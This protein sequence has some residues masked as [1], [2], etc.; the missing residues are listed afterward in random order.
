MRN[1][2][3]TLVLLATAFM[4]VVRW[5][6]YAEGLSVTKVSSYKDETVADP[7]FDAINCRTSWKNFQPTNST[8]IDAQFFDDC[9]AEAALYD[10]VAILE[11]VF[12]PGD[13]GK[14]ETIVPA[15]ATTAGVRT[16]YDFNKT[17][18]FPVWWNPTFKTYAKNAIQKL[19]E[20]YDP[21]PRVAGYMASGFAG[22]LPTSLAGEQS[23]PL[24]DNFKAE[25]LFG[26]CDEG[27][28][29]QTIASG[30]PYGIAVREMLGFWASTTTKPVVYVARPLDPGTLAVELEANPVAL[31]PNIAIV[32]NGFR[33]C[34]GIRGEIIDRFQALQSQGHIV[35]WWSLSVNGFPEDGDGNILPGEIAKA[36]Q[37]AV[38]DLDE[39]NMW[40]ALTANTWLDH[41]DAID[42]L[43]YALHPGDLP[44]PPPAPT[45]V[46]LN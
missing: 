42:T 2:T 38:D 34:D 10:K 12:T 5:P 14:N 32:N 16:V 4:T 7:R 9:V 36:I 35:G 8:T 27:A 43:Y 26:E 24:C 29:T 31:H 6:A 39:H 28:Q 25:G 21:D 13:I 18:Y 45:G 46:V 1:R 11:I 17:N 33:D 44:P 30:S 19:I 22:V 41:A 3:I 37:C 15:W 23:E 20:R 40:F